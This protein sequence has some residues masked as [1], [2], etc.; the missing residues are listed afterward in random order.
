IVKDLTRDAR[1]VERLP[2]KVNFPLEQRFLRLRPSTINWPGTFRT[3]KLFVLSITMKK[4]FLLVALLGAGFGGYSAWNHWQKSKLAAASPDRPT[5]ATVELR[6]INFA[7]N[8]AGEIGPAEQVS[9]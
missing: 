3:F 2:R 1:D 6:D 9:V 4:W 5:T 7:V 8:A